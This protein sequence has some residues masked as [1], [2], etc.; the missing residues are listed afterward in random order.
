MTLLGWLTIGIIAADWI[1]RF[2][3]AVRVIMRRTTV[4]ISLAWLLILLFAPFVGIALYALIGENRLGSRRLARHEAIEQRLESEIVTFRQHE[5]DSW[6]D[7]AVLYSHAARLASAVSGLPPLNG[8]QIELISDTDEWLDRLIADIDSATSHCHILTYIWSP[9]GRGAQ[10]GEAMIRAAQR[11]VECRVLVDSVGSRPFIRSDLASRMRRGGVQVVQA[12]PANVVRMLFARVDLRNHRKIVVID[13]RIGHAGSQNIT[14]RSFKLDVKRG[15]GPWIDASLRLRG[16][17]VDVLQSVFLADWF[18]DSGEQV[19]SLE[20]YCHGCD[21]ELETE[22]SC[23]VQVVPSRPGQALDAVHQMMLNAAYSANEEIIMTTP[24]FV[25]GEAMKEALCVAAVRGVNV[26]LVVPARLDSILVAA[27]SRA[28]YID[29]LEAGVSIY[30]YHGGL[31][32][33]KTMTVDRKLATIGSAN[34]D[35]RSFWLNLEITINVYDDDF[36]SWMRFMQ[37]EYVSHSTRVQLEHWKRRGVG[38]RFVENCVVLVS[39]LL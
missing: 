2:G 5:V 12:L 23:R 19:A 33:A 15:I 39:P 34:L 28:H 18:M 6:D 25:P 4:P 21:D 9:D 32:H 3:L 11:G 17:A 10:V 7:H 37:R 26:T 31:L 30:E 29:L 36:S 38:R 8:Q 35:M 27:A 22:N 14:D 13:G 16:P 24:Y 1:I 20:S